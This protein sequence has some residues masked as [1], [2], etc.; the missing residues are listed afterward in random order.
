[1]I[2]SGGKALTRVNDTDW[3][4]VA[5]VG[6]AGWSTQKWTITSNGD[7]SWRIE[8]AGKA[9]SGHTSSGNAVM[10]AAYNAWSGQKWYFF[11]EDKTDWPAGSWKWIYRKVTRTTRLVIDQDD[12][13]VLDTVVKG[14]GN[15]A[16]GTDSLTVN[17][18]RNVY[19]KRSQILDAHTNMGMTI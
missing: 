4:T 14:V 1:R 8:N 5:T 10:T 7:G 19:I 15:T 9:L 12:T 16:D 18:A 17:T 11:A 3:T 6:Y 13:L 2:E